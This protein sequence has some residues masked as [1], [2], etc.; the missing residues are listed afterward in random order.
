MVKSGSDRKSL[1]PFLFPL[2]VGAYQLG[3]YQSSLPGVIGEFPAANPGNRTGLGR[4]IWLCCIDRTGAFGLGLIHPL[5]RWILVAPG[6]DAGV[7]V[8]WRSQGW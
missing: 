1:Y 8:P 5:R 4:R 2:A 7:A 3:L 6:L